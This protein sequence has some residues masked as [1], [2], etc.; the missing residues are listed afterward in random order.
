MFEVKN[1]ALQIALAKSSEAG[2]LQ[3]LGHGSRR[4]LPCPTP[5]LLKIVPLAM[6][7]WFGRLS[8]GELQATTAYWPAGALGASARS[9]TPTAYAQAFE[10]YVR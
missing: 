8:C 1:R 10:A 4:T 6:T 9:N 3:R 5:T 7:I 2:I